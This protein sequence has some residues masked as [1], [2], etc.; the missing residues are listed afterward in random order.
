MKFG[1]EC[2]CVGT[3][4]KMIIYIT[5]GNR[6]EDIREY[7]ANMTKIVKAAYEVRE[8]QQIP[9]NEVGKILYGK[10]ENE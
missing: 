5:D 4:R 2:A 9:K 3:D 7:M 6:K 1:L 8:I 10:L